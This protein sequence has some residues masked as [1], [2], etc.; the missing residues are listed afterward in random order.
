MSY[1]LTA[2]TGRAAKKM[3]EVTGISAYTLHRLL[4]IGAD[5]SIDIDEID[6]NCDYI[7]CDESSMISAT[8]FKSLIYAC[9]E[10]NISLVL[11]GDHNQLPPVGKGFVFNE[12]IK[13]SIIP[14]TKL[15]KLYRQAENSQ[16]YNNALKVLKGVKYNDP[17][18][19]TFKLEKQDF[20]F[21][22]TQTQNATKNLILK[23]V[24]N[25]MSLGMTMDDIV[26][27][28]PM[29]KSALGSIEL[30]KFIQSCINTNKDGAIEFSNSKYVFRVGDKVMQIKNNYQIEVS[31]ERGNKNFGVFNGDI[32][33]IENIDLDNDLFTI[34]YDNGVMG[35]S[36]V[37]YNIDDA[38]QISLA[39]ALTVHKSQGCEF[40]CVILPYDY[41]FTNINRNMIYTSITRAKKRVIMLGE[42][43]V[44]FKGIQ[45]IDSTNIISNLNNMLENHY[46]N[47]KYIPKGA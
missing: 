37:T 22:S 25:L 3:T 21:F 7:I 11:V 1:I 35:T 23:C 18:G 26:I 43:D 10:K 19:L 5:D 6:I 46:N 38:D 36:H 41:S 44:M 33:I 40:P 16:I 45:K 47:L 4:Y 27:L 29:A 8:I 15:T 28:S 34:K 2:P 20:F 32:G 9:T 30:N 39:Y 42:P 13:S 31:D 12:L 14:V 17:D 24:N